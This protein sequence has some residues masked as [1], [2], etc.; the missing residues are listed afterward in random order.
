MRLTS[1]L[2]LAASLVALAAAP[3]SADA[4]GQFSAHYANSDFSGFDVDNWGVSG[5][6][7]VPFA[8][9]GFNG[10]FGADYN[11][12]DAG[13]GDVDVWDLSGNL[14]WR[15]AKGTF[16]GGVGYSSISV[17]GAD[18][19]FWTF[20]LAGEHYATDMFTLQGRG[21]IIEGDLDAW[22]LGGA[23]K[24]YPVADFALTGGIDYY[25]I[26][27]GGQLT[28]FGAS[29]EWMPSQQL[30]VAIFGGYTLTDIS[31][32]GG[33]VDT[34]TLGL[35]FYFGGPEGSLRDHQRS[36]DADWTATARQALLF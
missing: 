16:G 6:V 4:T 28:S 5:D 27:G 29:A 21:G 7:A 22:F 14:F 17:T 10:Q 34:W 20:G 25:D 26:D 3:A 15:D 11:N 12:F 23:L 13:G 9:S 35:R 24:I 36:G 8:N 32:G 33:D 1:S 18:A 30:P 2:F 19:D 31:G